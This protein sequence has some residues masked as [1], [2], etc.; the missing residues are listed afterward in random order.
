MLTFD[1]KKRPT[2]AQCME[3]PWIKNLSQVTVNE[4]TA[5]NALD[6][7]INFHSHSTMKAATLTYIGSQLLTK[8]EREELARVF[9][10]MDAN[11]DGKLSKDE[12]KNGYQ[13]HY[14]KII[15][16]KEVD[17]MFDAVDTDQSGYIDY[18]E[19]VVAAMNEKDMLTKERLSA[20]FKMY[21]KDN[22]GTI[23]PQEIKMVLNAQENKL[24]QA[25]IDKILKQV[26]A[27][28]DGQISFDE[29]SQLMKNAAM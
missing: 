27:N 20:A 3:D 17:Q 28:G 8:G 6:N 13:V 12:I 7:L 19:F 25:V 9:K 14:G 24:P 15:S 26:D 21:D 2:A 5:Q 18:T 4:S 23:S 10:K 1:A 11:G 22:S 29:F 16:D